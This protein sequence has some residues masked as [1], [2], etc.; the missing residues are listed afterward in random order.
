M[1]KVTRFEYSSAE[2]I[3]LNFSDGSQGT[4]N[5]TAYLSEHHGSL[6]SPLHDPL[7]AKRVFIDAGALCWPNGLEISPTRLHEYTQAK[8]AA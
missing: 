4:F 3:L 1:I 6:L 7:Y 2:N 8:K 5:L